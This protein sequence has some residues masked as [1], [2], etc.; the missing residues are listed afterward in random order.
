MRVPTFDHKIVRLK[1]WR[2]CWA[3][4]VLLVHLQSEVPNILVEIEGDAPPM[5][6]RDMHRFVPLHSLNLEVFREIS[7][8]NAQA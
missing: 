5:T 7:L 1:W 4:Y 2:F 3:H 8:L 6:E